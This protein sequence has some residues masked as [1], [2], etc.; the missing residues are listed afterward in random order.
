MGSAH[1]ARSCTSDRVYVHACVCWAPARL[2]ACPQLA[3]LPPEPEATIVFDYPTRRLPLLLRLA[4]R[5]GMDPEAGPDKLPSAGAAAAFAD[6]AAAACVLLGLHALTASAAH[7]MGSQ[8]APS[9]AIGA[10][11]AVE[12]LP[13]G[14]AAAAWLMSLG[15]GDREKLL[16]V[17]RSLASVM[18]GGVH[19]YS[20]EAEVLSRTC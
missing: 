7:M 5:A 17:W 4:Q 2:P 16:A 19:A 15:E 6:G 8:L 3:K 1:W 20:L 9:A 14:G 10:T 13:A 12:A 18:D 11:T